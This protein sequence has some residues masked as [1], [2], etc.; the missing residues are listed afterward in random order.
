MLKKITNIFDHFNKAL[1][2]FAGAIAIFVMLAINYE[3]FMRYFLNRPT[4][5]TL[6]IS[7]YSLVYITFLGAAWVLSKDGHVKIDLLFKALKPRSQ[8]VLN[9][10]TSIM[11]AGLSILFTWYSVQVTWSSYRNLIV[12]VTDLETPLFL[13][14]LAIP[15]GCFL[16]FVQFLRNIVGILSKWKATSKTGM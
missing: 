15:I 9:I 10:I 14:Q 16:L 5:W 3:V 11:G 6:E 12:S 1:F 7:E 2:F 8:I 13:V 4:L